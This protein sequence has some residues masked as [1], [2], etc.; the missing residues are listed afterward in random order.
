MGEQRVPCSHTVEPP[1]R[2]GRVGRCLPNW[3]SSTYFELN[4]LLD[5]DTHLNERELSTVITCDSKS[6]LYALST[7][8]LMAE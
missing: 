7:P 1:G 8:G 2:N 6:A 3:S 5:A 4:D